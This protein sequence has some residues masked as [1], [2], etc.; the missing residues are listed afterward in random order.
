MKRMERV[1]FELFNES[2]FPL[3]AK[4]IRSV[5]FRQCRIIR[6][7]KCGPEDDRNFHHFVKKKVA[8]CFFGCTIEA[9][10]RD[11]LLFLFLTFTLTQ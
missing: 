4:R 1:E 8:L 10:I 7:L 2:T 9:G 6:H 5:V 3:E 11:V